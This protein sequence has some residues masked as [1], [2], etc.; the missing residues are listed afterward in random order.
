MPTIS[1][2]N[3]SDQISVSFLSVGVRGPA[4]SPSSGSCSR[5]TSVLD[6][7][8]CGPARLMASSSLRWSSR[9]RIQGVC[10]HRHTYGN[11]YIVLW[12]LGTERSDDR[13][14]QLFVVVAQN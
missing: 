2:P 14:G 7:I 4:Y 8:T 1:I 11:A 9:I 10:Y 5:R 6:S 12:F 13:T 3:S